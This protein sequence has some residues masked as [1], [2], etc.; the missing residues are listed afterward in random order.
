MSEI[1]DL[2]DRLPL[3]L[4]QVATYAAARPDIRLAMLAAHLRDGHRRAFTSPRSRID[5]RQVL[6]RP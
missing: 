1:I 2:C 4:A 3:Y 5:D 6:R